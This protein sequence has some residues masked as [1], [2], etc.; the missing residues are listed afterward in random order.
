MP[1]FK[2]GFSVNSIF[3]PF[4]SMATRNILGCMIVLV[5]GVE[6]PGRVVVGGV[7]AV[8]SPQAANSTIRMRLNAVPMLNLE[9]M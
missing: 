4:K 3:A 8:E 7:E 1:S 2:D 9:K 5:A 6:L